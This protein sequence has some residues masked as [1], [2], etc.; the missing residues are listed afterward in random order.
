[1]K[2][3]D[4]VYEKFKEDITQGYLKYGDLL[5]SIR[6]SVARFGYSKTTI[7]HAYDRLLM[8]G[9]ITSL[10]QKGFVV[11]I[12]PDQI[13]R[14]QSILQT[15]QEPVTKMYPYDFRQHA[16]SQDSFDV[17]IWKRYMK[18]VFQDGQLISTYG[19]EQGEKALRIALAR[20][21]YQHRG[22][23]TTPEQILVGSNF[24]TLLFLFCSLL[25]R[26]TVIGM[27]EGVSKQ[28]LRVFHSY[29]FECILLSK[30]TY[31]EELKESSIDVLYI[32]SACFGGQYRP[33]DALSRDQI[34]ALAHEK[35]FLILE[36]DY[37]GELTYR[38][39]DRHALQGFESQGKVI[40]CSSF[41]R[42]LIPSLR[43]SYMVL[44]ED[45][46][47]R[48]QEAK[49]E[50][51][52]TASKFE[53]LALAKYIENGC[54]E[55][56]VR[57]LKREYALK[58]KLARSLLQPHFDGLILKEAYFSYAFTVAIQDLDT[59]YKRC[60]KQGIGIDHIEKNQLSIS[61]AYP[62]QK[63]L[64]EGLCLLVKIIK[65]C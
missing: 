32:N 45:F 56:H 35:D 5:P 64:K 12:Q 6:Q 61:F 55:K 46:L 23:L 34:I 65:E 21:A 51:G 29:G 60:E 31:F 53:Q 14:H 47:Q 9:Y 24:Q 16:V 25:K 18:E 8:D 38:S 30:K 17:Q 1:M 52:P 43:L 44:N 50:F 59:F 13:Q 48:Y 39:K 22:V 42:L 63:A 11:D 2:R 33:L 19:Q 15:F 57:R 28:V 10:P 49:E 37:N 27:E 54:M 7:E 58:E 36:D 62:N 40:Y 41:S 26:P 4:K 3:Y 20:Y